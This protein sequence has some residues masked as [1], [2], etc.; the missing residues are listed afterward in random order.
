MR[1]PWNGLSSPG[2]L[3]QTVRAAVFCI[4]TTLIE[5][6]ACDTWSARLANEGRVRAPVVTGASPAPFP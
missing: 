4:A 5:T 3:L 2:E 6:T 1:K